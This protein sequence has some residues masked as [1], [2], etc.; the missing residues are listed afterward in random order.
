MIYELRTYLIP[1]GRMPDILDRFATVTMR[2]FERHG[3]EVVG[4]W[5]VAQP[6]SEPAL[7]Y[8][9]R[10]ADDSAQQR[11]WQ[12]FRSDPEWVAARARTEAGGP[13]VTQ[14]ITQNLVPTSFSP[15]Q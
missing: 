15:L 7:V 9:V 2:L 6:D 1:A 11:A 3:I 14:V 4:F 13:I 5:T 8:L 12:A 10:F